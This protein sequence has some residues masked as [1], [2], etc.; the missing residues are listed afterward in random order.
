MLADAE[1]LE[2]REQCSR[3]VNISPFTCLAVAAWKVNAAFSH[4]NICKPL[5]TWHPVQHFHSL[6]IKRH[7]YLQQ[8]APHL[9]HCKL[10]A[11]LS[12]CSA[13][14]VVIWDMGMGQYSN[15]YFKKWKPGE[16]NTTTSSILILPVW[17]FL[18]TRNSSFDPQQK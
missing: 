14:Y 13:L 8:N 15:R 9:K 3:V 4:V 7:R 11:T 5:P 1:I 6:V 16:V 12:S 10:A 17:S 2:K 18:M